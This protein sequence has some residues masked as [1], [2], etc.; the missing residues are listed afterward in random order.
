[1]KL[2]K[3]VLSMVLCGLVVL[4][5]S[6]AAL[7]KADAQTVIAAGNDQYRGRWTQGVRFG[8]QLK[9]F[10]GTK[11]GWSLQ[12]VHKDGHLTLTGPSNV[13][14]TWT[15]GDTFHLG[16]LRDGQT[17]EQVFR[18]GSGSAGNALGR[19][20]K[21]FNES[22]VHDGDFVFCYGENWQTSVTFDGPS[23]IKGLGSNDYSRGYQ[24]GRIDKFNA[25]F[26]I[27]DHGLHEAL[28]SQHIK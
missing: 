18:T 17:H 12:F 25:G 11:S 10:S 15:F 8:M 2:T 20:M 22:N 4:G 13:G 5:G 28:L 16:F 6:Q 21:W 27:D 14:S 1:M 3:R 9:G 7:V 26:G 19:A 23:M 24:R